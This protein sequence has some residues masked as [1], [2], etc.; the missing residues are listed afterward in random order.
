MKN[1]FLIF[2]ILLMSL[3]TNSSLAE[4]DARAVANKAIEAGFTE[5]ERQ[6]IEEYFGGHEG[7]KQQQQQKEKGKPGSKKMPPGLAKKKELPTGLQKQLERNGTLPP[8]LAKRELPDDLEK[9]LPKTASGLERTIVDTSVV[10]IEKA[11]GRIVDIIQ[12]VVTGN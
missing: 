7:E 4:V 11:S 8:G 5:L 3:F 12:D 1:T 2:S 6:I 10:L 9:K